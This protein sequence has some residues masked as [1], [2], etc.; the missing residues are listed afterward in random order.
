MIG[1]YRIEPI[2]GE[3]GRLDVVDYRCRACG[4]LVYYAVWHGQYCPHCGAP[5][6][7]FPKKKLDDQ[8]RR[9]MSFKELDKLVYNGPKSRRR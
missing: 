1:Q 4:K 2:R 5:V 3:G 6:F 8:M 7:A 9:G